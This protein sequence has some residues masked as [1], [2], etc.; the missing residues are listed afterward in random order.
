MSWSHSSPASAHSSSGHGRSWTIAGSSF[1]NMFPEH[2]RHRS[3][4]DTPD[5]GA[6]AGGQEQS[7]MRL[8]DM[9]KRK[10]VSSRKSSR[11]SAGAARD[12]MTS[13]KTEFHR[14]YYDDL[15]NNPASTSQELFSNIY[16][17]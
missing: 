11:K 9:L 8:S 7:H 10:R 1:A 13:G 5:T 4:R 6:G 14:K 16:T 17:S 2:L 3:N 12:E 15:Q